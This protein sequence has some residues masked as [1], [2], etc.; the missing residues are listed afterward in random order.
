M[1]DLEG[2]QSGAV[3]DG[4][5]GCACCNLAEWL[6]CNGDGAVAAALERLYGVPGFSIGGNCPVDV[7]DNVD[8]DCLTRAFESDGHGVLGEFDGR[9]RSLFASDEREQRKNR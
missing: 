4:E 9:G 8:G 3:T 1:D 7:G 2:C 5:L 6:N